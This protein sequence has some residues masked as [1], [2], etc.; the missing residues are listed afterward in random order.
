[1][2]D[3]ATD[4][5]IAQRLGVFTRLFRPVSEAGKAMKEALTPVGELNEHAAIEDLTDRIA[6]LDMIGKEAFRRIDLYG[7]IAEKVDD[8]M[9]ANLSESATDAPETVEAA[10]DVLRELK[11]LHARWEPR[12]REG[13]EAA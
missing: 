9:L 5:D 13:T 10:L 4:H 6:Q 7:A 11:D 12:E 1:M 3:A 8:A 2:N